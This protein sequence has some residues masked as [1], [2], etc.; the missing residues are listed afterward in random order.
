MIIYVIVASLGSESH[1]NEYYLGRAEAD[2]A[3]EEKASH[4]ESY[5]WE[6]REVLKGD[7]G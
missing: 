6:V 2:A 7:K 4:D 3:C 1:L 5:R